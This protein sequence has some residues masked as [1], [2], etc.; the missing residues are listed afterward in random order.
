M[1][2]CESL[3][4]GYPGKVL[5]RDLSLVVKPG[6]CWGILGRNGSG[7]TTLVHALG[8]LR[9]PFGGHVTLQGRSLDAYA[10]R[11]LARELG[12]L[13]Q[14]EAHG[15]WGSVLEYVLLGRHPHA[16]TLFG[17]QAG[18][19]EIATQSI[20]Q[21]DLAGIEHRPLNTL[22]GGE[23]QRARIALL[24]AQQPRYYL[25][26]EPLQHLDLRHQLETMALFRELATRGGLA[27]AMV[28]H[29]TLWASRYC[30]HVLLLYEGGR[31]LAGPTWE[32][33]TR[34]NLEALYQCVL[35]EFGADGKRHFVPGNGRDVPRVYNPENCINDSKIPP[36]RS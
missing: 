27:V 15:F 5:C 17:W 32:L 35:E 8:G 9:E 2:Q 26:D 16:R 31:A 36:P 28:L 25:L 19:I 13:L 34:E 22:S 23:R 7:K 10:R 3:S 14:D 11:D 4:L 24:L 30:D 20:A 6:E 1:L 12:V 18:D 29:D 21:L 33:L